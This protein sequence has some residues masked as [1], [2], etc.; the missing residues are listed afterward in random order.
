LCEY[1]TPAKE[2]IYLP[3]TLLVTGKEFRIFFNDYNRFLSGLT[4]DQLLVLSEYVTSKH[5]E[6]TNGNSSGRV[7]TPNCNCTPGTNQC[8]ADGFFNDCCVCCG[9]NMAACG[10]TVGI[11]SCRCSEEEE[12]ERIS[13][14][15]YSDVTFYPREFYAFLAY[16]DEN[17]IKVEIIRRSLID[18][19]SSSK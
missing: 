6:E 17:R 18:L 19:V 4:S 10:V 1:N 11:A 13:D 2:T 15:A 7:K 12:N 5:Y 16:A 8:S 14:H 3:E 9:Q